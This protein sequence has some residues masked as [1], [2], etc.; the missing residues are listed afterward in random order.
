MEEFLNEEENEKMG[1]K[2]KSASEHINKVKGEI[3]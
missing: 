2:W 3:K 1:S